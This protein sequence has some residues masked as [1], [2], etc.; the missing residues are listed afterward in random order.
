MRN[1]IMWLM[2]VL[3]VG[4]VGLQSAHAQVGVN[5][6]TNGGF[7]NGQIGPYGIYGA[8]TGEIVTDCVGAAVPEGPVEGKYSLHVVVP[9]AGANNWDVGLSDGSL[10]FQQGKKYTFSCFFKV[11]TGT[12]Q[13]R[14]KPERA[15][16]PWEGYG[17]QVFTATDK[18]QEFSV[19]TPVIST[20][21]T[22]ASAT[23]HFAFAAGDFWMD[24]IRFYEGDY[25]PLV[26]PVAHDP[27]PADGSAHPDTWASLSWQ[28]G[29]FAVTHDVY[30]GTS[31]DDVSTG[32]ANAF[33]GNQPVTFFI[34]GFPGQPY[35]DGLV[36][37][38]TY[39]WRVD[40]VN[41]ADPNSP[42]KGKVWSFLVP[43]KKAYAPNPP[44]A[45]KFLD[46]KVTLTWKAGMGAKIHQV[47]FGD[48]LADV[49]AGTGGTAKG[50]SGAATY[51]PSG[52]QA[53]KAYYW[54]IDEFDGAT[55]YKGD[56]W[57]FTTGRIGGGVRADYYK[58]MNFESRVLTKTDP[59][60]NFNWGNNAP[61]P[62]VGVDSFSVRWTGE[63]EAAFTETYT[64]YVNTDD[65]VRLW[66]DGQL[67]VDRWVDQAPTE[68]FGRVDLVAGNTYSFVMEYY[69]NGGG[70]V[71][72]LRWSSPR[73]PKQL[74]P[75]AALSLPL[76]AN[77]PSPRNGSVGVA[78][79]TSLTWGAG[80]NAASHDVYFGTDPS[81]VKNATKT[82]PEY[83]GTRTR[84]SESYTPGPLEWET[85]Y[86]WRIDEVNNVKPASPWVGNV[87]SFTTTDHGIV[88]NFE[89]YNDIAAGQ[90]GSNLVYMTWL[91][92]FGTTT[93]GSTM[94]YPTGASLETTNVHGGTKAAPLIYNNVTA[95][96]SEV[97]RTFAA[98]NW[99]RNGIQTL[100]LW[101]YGNP[102]NVAGQ[103]Y[104]KINGVKVTYNG[105]AANLKK[106]LWQVWNITLA[107]VGVNL[108]S[109]TKLAV[110]IE[111]KGTTGTLLLDDIELYATAPVVGE[112]IWLEAE[113]GTIT[114]PLTV[115]AD[116]LASGGSYIGT[117][118]GI[119]D[120]TANP[121]ATGVATYNFTAQGG[122]YKISLRVIITGGSNSFWVRIPGATNYAPGTHTSGWIRFNDISD[123]AAWHWD[124]VHSSDHTN[125]VVTITVPAGP[126]TLEIARRE[127]GA[128]LDAI[129]IT[130][131]VQ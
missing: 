85:T 21:V 96:F 115:R 117:D 111:T 60:I 47:Y 126:Q 103:L 114:A 127:D 125:A 43:P 24:G 77:S 104:V 73:T 100:S 41:Q 128:M 35:P 36:P 22:P 31:F 98:Q 88:D 131:V 123:G 56:V 55:T 9:A 59:Q 7:E 1:R 25:V 75:Q 26:S 121:P 27:D 80:D 120:E 28:P 17:D 44:D 79:T 39:Y 74:I 42:W 87:W 108:Q 29:N 102:A 33:Y 58:G 23:F 91:D 106:P 19:T 105:D 83:K 89:S 67:L 93:N 116:P 63:V 6:L 112:Q 40:E 46:M 11:K 66:V 30:F 49:E 54:R 38:T 14:M 18:W 53:D 68:N 64:F 34:V 118:D 78:D 90:P 12:L 81:A 71:A 82:S 57:V 69:E 52:L 92:G 86:S 3:L 4:F 32:A 65:G 122:V 110:G 124:E 37:G 72:E 51:T 97:E 107:S 70:A 130:S 119:G 50:P 94:G 45:A 113:A 2:A 84:G 99:T 101:F 48:K 95:S 62:A 15:A 109:V 76:K 16:S 10:T 5:L 20:T 13:F 8:G 129:L 61:D